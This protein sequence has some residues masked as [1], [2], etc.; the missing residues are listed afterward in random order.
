MLLRTSVGF[1]FT[2][3]KKRKEGAKL[4][5]IPIIKNDEHHKFTPT[6]P[7]QGIANS[8]QIWVEKIQSDMI[9]ISFFIPLP[10]YY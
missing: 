4:L 7:L 5:V 1:H 3:H 8:E 6:K 10:F 2:Q 9:P